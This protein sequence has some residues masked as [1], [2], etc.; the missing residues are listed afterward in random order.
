MV[1]VHFTDGSVVETEHRFL[2]IASMGLVLRHYNTQGV[3]YPWD[4][5]KKIENWDQP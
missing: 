5:I 3:F 4:K 2:G 1:T